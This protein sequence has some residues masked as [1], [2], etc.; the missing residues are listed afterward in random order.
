MS[1]NKTLFY[2]GHTA[3]AGCGLALAA[4]L[5]VNAA[6]PE[7]I[8]TNA[9]G[10]LEVFTTRSPQTAWGVP[11]IHSLFENQASVATGIAAALKMKG[12]ADKVKVMAFGGDGATLI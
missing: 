6:G 2:S 8:V 9:T 1:E 10:C 11:W 12:L 5:V 4:R 3:C 7:V